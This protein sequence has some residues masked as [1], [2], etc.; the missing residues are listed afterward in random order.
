MRRRETY[1][2]PTDTL[3]SFARELDRGG[4]GVGE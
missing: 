4:E 2:C 1:L 3:D